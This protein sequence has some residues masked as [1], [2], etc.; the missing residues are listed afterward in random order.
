MACTEELPFELIWKLCP[1]PFYFVMESCEGHYVMEKLSCP[2]KET[3]AP[4]HFH[5]VMESCEGHYIMEKLK[6][7][8]LNFEKCS[9]L[10][11]KK[12]V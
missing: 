9:L 7:G 4:S 2:E 3:C 1:P 8:V 10:A 6:V 11:E 12:P 5:C